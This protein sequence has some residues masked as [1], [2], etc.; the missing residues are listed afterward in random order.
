[1]DIK[2]F[3]EMFWAAVYM[4]DSQFGAPVGAITTPLSELSNSTAFAELC[5]KY[6]NYIRNGI[7]ISIF[8]NS[9]RPHI[10]PSYN[11]LFLLLNINILS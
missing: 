6:P 7:L 8:I 10:N 11:M 3:M 9:N 1:V 4:S 5:A 2:G